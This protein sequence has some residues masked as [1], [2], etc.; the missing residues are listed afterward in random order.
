LVQIPWAK[1]RE[2]TLA[3]EL[4]QATSQLGRMLAFVH[5]PRGESNRKCA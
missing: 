1:T 3:A 5:R 4:A 2:Q